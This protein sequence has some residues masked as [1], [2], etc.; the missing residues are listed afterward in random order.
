MTVILMRQS[1]VSDTVSPNRQAW[2]FPENVGLGL[3]CRSGCL[4][5]EAGSN[6][7]YNNPNVSA[8]NRAVVFSADRSLF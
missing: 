6:W 3:A 5:G 4:C 7:S 2:P 8:K 1:F